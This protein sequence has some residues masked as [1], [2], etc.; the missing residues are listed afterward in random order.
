MITPEDILLA[1][2]VLNTK[3]DISYLADTKEVCT[4][5]L[6]VDLFGLNHY[7]ICSHVMRF[8]DGAPKY[9][10]NLDYYFNGAE[11]P[12]E[13]IEDVDTPTEEAFKKCVVSHLRKK[14]KYG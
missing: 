13:T 5:I 9:Q 3:T 8:S 11:D 12:T 1:D 4:Y 7:Y 10:W 6:S 14:V 2:R